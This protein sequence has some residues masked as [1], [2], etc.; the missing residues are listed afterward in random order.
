[1][2]KKFYRL[3]IN[4]QGPA[5]DPANFA[6]VEAATIHDAMAIVR[7][8]FGQCGGNNGIPTSWPKTSPRSGEHVLS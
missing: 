8:E 1:M 4:E 2:T 6:F 5:V 3:R 7:R